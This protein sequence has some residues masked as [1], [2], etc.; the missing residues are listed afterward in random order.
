MAVFIVETGVKVWS[1]EKAVF[2]ILTGIYTK[3]N[4]MQGKLMDME[5][6]T[7]LM[8]LVIK[9]TGKMICSTVMV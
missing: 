5:H 1:Q 4:G 9:V 8:V 3:D 7:I 6:F 2:Y